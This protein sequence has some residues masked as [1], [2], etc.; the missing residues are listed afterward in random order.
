MSADIH[1]NQTNISTPPAIVSKVRFDPVR[2]HLS[3]LADD[4]KFSR[5][6]PD[7]YDESIM[8]RVATMVTSASQGSVLESIS[9]IISTCGTAAKLE[10]P[11]WPRLPTIGDYVDLDALYDMDEVENAFYEAKKPPLSE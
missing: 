6:N 2:R 11:L 10:K 3:E 9:K 5:G 8:A 4:L 7:I 1:L